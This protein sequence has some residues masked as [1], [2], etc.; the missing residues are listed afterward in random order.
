[1]SFT[2]TINFGAGASSFGLTLDT[3][4]NP[5]SGAAPPAG[6]PPPGLSSLPAGSS[7][8]TV[9][10]AG[11][12][13]LFTSAMGVA[14]SPPAGAVVLT[15]PTG[16]AF[17]DL[18]TV[19]SSPSSPA[20][21]IVKPSS[22]AQ[23]QAASCVNGDGTFYGLI[24]IDLSGLPPG[25][26]DL[27]TQQPFIQI[28]TPGSINGMVL[29]NGPPGPITNF[30]NAFETQPT[31][32]GISGGLAIQFNNAATGRLG[33]FTGAG[34][35]TYNQANINM[36]MKFLNNTGTPVFKVVSSRIVR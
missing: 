17:F 27:S 14:A 23:L 13:S 28:G 29:L 32:T 33:M 7:V 26:V 30:D 6:S 8:G 21:V 11:I 24:I 15:A 2:D 36:A 5:L 22:V 20:L 3:P 1:M 34:A 10:A 9:P 4:Q 31:T 35:V 19:S 18:G 25:P 12:N 16:T